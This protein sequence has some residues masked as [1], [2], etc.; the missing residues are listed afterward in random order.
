MVAWPDYDGI[1]IGTCAYDRTRGVITITITA[2]STGSTFNR[3]R[4]SNAT[5]LVLPAEEP[6]L[7]PLAERR[8]DAIAGVAAL[9]PGHARMPV[10]VGYA[11]SV[12]CERGQG[13]E[14]ANTGKQY[15]RQR[16]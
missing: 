3:S 13:R 4:V 1:N 5:A 12:S 6:R 15:R 9:R 7:A 2:N 10:S 16:S 8:A 11:R 14:A